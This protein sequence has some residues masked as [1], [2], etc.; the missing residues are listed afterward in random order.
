M[1]LYSRGYLYSKHCSM[2]FLCKIGIFRDCLDS[3]SDKRQLLN[4]S[5]TSVID[6]TTSPS[7]SPIKSTRQGETS[8]FRGRLL[9]LRTPSPERPSNRERSPI[10]VDSS[11]IQSVISDSE[12][13]I[14]E[15]SAS[16][17]KDTYP[18]GVRP[19]TKKAIIKFEE[20]S[21]LLL[22]SSKDIPRSACTAVPDKAPQSSKE[23]TFLI[24]LQAI[25]EVEDILVDDHGSWGKSSG[26]NGFYIRNKSG[27]Y[28]KIDA[29]GNL[30]PGEDFDV[31]IKKLSYIHP[32]V[33]GKRLKK[34]FSLRKN[35]QES[36]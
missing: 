20:A 36:T 29:D 35:H 7:L 4:Q 1:G 34:K 26:K 30:K 3:P 21:E 6:L 9:S 8:S 31:K 12:D 23:A 33:Q 24:D 28:K 19:L 18:I 22:R 5:F 15:L 13:E 16:R 32:A 17:S 14:P 27:E 2:Q 10:E 11:P 25:S